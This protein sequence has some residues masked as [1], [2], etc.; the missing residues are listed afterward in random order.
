[1][2]SASENFEIRPNNFDPKKYMPIIN[3]MLMIIYISK[4][5]LRNSAAGLSPSC[6]LRRIDSG[7][8][9]DISILLIKLENKIIEANTKK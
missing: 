6:S 4:K 8:R 1:M 2:I 3:N 7:I 5:K 9:T